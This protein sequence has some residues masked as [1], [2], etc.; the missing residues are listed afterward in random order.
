M[1]QDSS[2]KTTTRKKVEKALINCGSMSSLCLVQNCLPTV[3]TWWT[4][5]T[6]SKLLEDTSVPQ[7]N[8]NPEINPDNGV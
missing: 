2:Q 8:R 4:K 1:T 7:A 6:I 3:H 5:K